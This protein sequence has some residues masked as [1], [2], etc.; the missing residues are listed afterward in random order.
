M[1]VEITKDLGN[2]VAL[3]QARMGS[4]RFPN[5]MLQ[6]LGPRTILEWVLRRTHKANSIDCV[7]LATSENKR[8][9]LLGDKAQTLGSNVFYGSETDVLK[10]LATAATFY[11]ADTVVRICADNPFIDPKEIDRLVLSFRSNAC[12]YACNHQDRLNSEYADG[13]GAEILSNDLFQKVNSLA[14]SSDHREHATLYLWDNPDEFRVYSLPAPSELAYPSMKFDIDTPEDLENL[15]DLVS[16]G[17]SLK[18]T[19]SEIIQIALSK[20]S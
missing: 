6:K 14:T 5:K 17:V 12:D 19:A 9:S 8:D 7:V 15:G 18:S 2:V 4:S 3:I 13:F 20:T 1:Q 10:R 16:R 11:N